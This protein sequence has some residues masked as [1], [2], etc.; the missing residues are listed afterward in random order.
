[1]TAVLNFHPIRN[2]PKGQLS[3]ILCGDNW[4]FTFYPQTEGSRR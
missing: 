4:G 2:T 1:M 3:G